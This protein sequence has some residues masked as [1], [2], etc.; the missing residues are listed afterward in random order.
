MTATDT[1]EPLKP[2]AMAFTL[3]S[4][5]LTAACTSG[6]SDG[7]LGAGRTGPRGGQGPRDTA[8]ATPVEAIQVKAAAAAQRRFEKAIST[9]KAG[10]YLINVEVDHDRE[11]LQ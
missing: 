1:A 8:D 6:S 10:R 3:L 9:D 2:A 5:D 11:V 7:L 4:K